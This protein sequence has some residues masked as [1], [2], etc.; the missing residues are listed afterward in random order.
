MS[1]IDQ[2]E[3]LFKAA[4]KPACALESLKIERVL[5]VTD[6]PEPEAATLTDRV[7]GF[8]SVL[9]GREGPVQYDSLGAGD[10]DSVSDLIQ[11]IESSQDAAPDLIVTYRHLHSDGWRHAFGLG[12]YLDVLT[13]ATATPVLVIPHPLAGDDVQHPLANTDRVMAIT[14]HLAGDD[15]LVTWAL[16]LTRAG[17]VCYLSHVEDETTFDRTMEVISKIPSIDTDMARELIGER[18]LKEAGDYI[19]TCRR[20]ATEHGATASI[21]SVVRMGCQLGDYE[22]LVKSHDIDLLVMNTKDHDQMAMHGMAYPLAV[23]LRGVP[24]LML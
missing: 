21:E 8:L 5:V 24:L 4:D 22:Q 19:E 18:L 6:L 23:Q 16:R 1:H 7:A 3:S 2:Y 15:H 11:K 17:G 13:Q 20:A 14:D 9:A 10:F 12:A